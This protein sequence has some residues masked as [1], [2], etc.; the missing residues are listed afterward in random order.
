MKE[1]DRE[2]IKETENERKGQRKKERDRQVDRSNGFI[3]R[4]HKM[5]YRCGRERECVCAHEYCIRL[6][7][8]TVSFHLLPDNSV[9]ND[10]CTVHS[11]ARTVQ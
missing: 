4:S 10:S 7:G 9:G 8:H 3:I 6:H 2:L 1:R 5:V 11:P